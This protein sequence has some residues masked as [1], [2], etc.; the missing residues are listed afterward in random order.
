MKLLLTYPELQTYI[1]DHYGKQIETA[2]VSD[3]TICVSYILKILFIKKTIS[4]DISIDKVDGTDIYLSH[5][6][7]I[8]IDL[9]V[10]GALKF[11]KQTL[12]NQSIE[13][14]DSE[15]I[16]IHLNQIE[17]LNKILEIMELKNICFDI[18]HIIIEAKL[19]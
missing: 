5:R 18:Q 16:I 7:G 14:V 3:N 4:I 13:I 9:I 15:K 8:G 6:G 17:T 19:K 11:L 2:Y 12:N 1:N 10:K